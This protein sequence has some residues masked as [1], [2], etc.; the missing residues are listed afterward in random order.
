[1]EAEAHIDLLR[2]ESEREISRL[3]VFYFGF[4]WLNSLCSF[5]DLGFF[6]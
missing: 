4:V 3:G 2:T 6:T 1:V 5:L